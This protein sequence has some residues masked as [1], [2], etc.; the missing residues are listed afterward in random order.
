MIKR[1]SGFKKDCVI[2]FSSCS[3]DSIVVFEEAV[4][5]CFCS[6]SCFCSPTCEKS[7]DEDVDNDHWH[8]VGTKAAVKVVVATDPHRT[9]RLNGVAATDREAFRIVRNILMILLWRQRR[10]CTCSLARVV[11]SET[12]ILYST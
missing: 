10:Y 2:Q 1:D 7:L 9:R 6:C 12:I 11:I 3:V 8:D 4:D 5:C